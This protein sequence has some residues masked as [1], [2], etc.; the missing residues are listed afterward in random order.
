M[1]DERV[2]YTRFDTTTP[3]TI[4]FEAKLYIP[5]LMKIELISH[6]SK[7]TCYMELN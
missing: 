1:L 3:S 7:V 6:W 5:Y 4:C 2:C